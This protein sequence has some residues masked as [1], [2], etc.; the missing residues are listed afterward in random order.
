MKAQRTGGRESRERARRSIDEPPF[1]FTLLLYAA[2]FVLSDLLKPKPDLENAKPAGLGDFQFPTATEGRPV[3]LVWGTVKVSGPNVTWYGDLRQEAITIEVK[4][5][6]FSGS[7]EQVVGF[8]YRLGM[9]L[10]LC[11]GPIDELRKVWIG[12]KLVFTGSVTHGNTLTIDEP[13][14]FG[15]D[16]LGQGG[17]LATLRLFGGTNNQAASTYLSA[18]YVNAA[19]IVNAGAGYSVGQILTVQGG[20]FTIPARIKVTT[21]GGGGAITGAVIQSRGNYSAFPS[22]PAAVDAGA[23]TFNLT[24]AGF[25]AVGGVTPAYPDICYLVP[26][27]DPPYLGNSTSIQPWSFEI[28]RCPNALAVTA[29]RHVVNDGDANPMCVLFEALTNVDWGRGIPTAEIN[30]VNLRAVAVTLFDE[31]NGFS[32]LLDRMEDVG[33]LIRRI[34]E[35]VSGV[36]YQ[37]PTNGLWEFKLT[38]ADYDPLTIPELNSTNI[39]EIRTFT[40][41][42]WEGCTNQVRVPFSQRDDSY[43]DTYGFAQDMALV[44]IIGANVSSSVTHP[45]IKDKTLANNVA[46]RTLRT[47]AIPLAQGVFVVDRTFYGVLPGDVLALTDPDLGFVRL[48]MRVKSVDYGHLL[49]GEILIDTVQDVFYSAQGSFAPPAPSSWTPPSDSLV[50]FPPDEQRAFEAPRALTLRDPRSS[51]AIADMVYALAR[52]QGPEVSFKMMQRNA[53]G[54]PAG[55]FAEFGESFGF[56]RIGALNLALP[57]GSAVPLSTLLV[58]PTPDTQGALEVAFPDVT[59]LVQ[60]GTDLLTLCLIDEEFILVSSAQNNGANVQLNNVYR[61]VLDSVQAAH[62]IGA[63]VYLVFV[64]AAMGAL[65]IPA[66]RNVE[67]KLLPRSQSA[68]VPEASATTIAFTM[69]NRTRRPY[70]PC[71]LSLNSSR[72]PSSASLEGTGSGEAIGIGLTFRRRDFRT[73]DEIGA[74]LADAATLFADFP[75]ANSTTHEVDVRNDPNGANTLLF[76]QDLAALASG[77]LRRLDI[78]EATN[79]DLPT[80]LRVALRAKHSFEST[81]YASRYDLVWDFNITSALTGFFEFTALLKDEI[82][83]VFT[84]VNDTTD[85]VFTLSSAFTVGDVEYRINAGAWTQLIAAGNTSGTIPNAAILAGDTIEVVHRS[86]DTNAQKLL[87]MAAGSTPAFGVLYT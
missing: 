53:V 44:R 1:W 47:L 74:L 10:A 78:L 2:L 5:G 61:G 18:R 51:S 86:T 77:T 29:D 23:A 9:Q 49:E 81:V 72:F 35:Q 17:V 55:A 43:K 87:T 63:P 79:G 26:D 45:G 83:A 6:I 54:S 16:D 50:P 8:K 68:L 15:G 52:R 60:L 22:N 76:T 82:S 4:T 85:H 56:V 70:A 30:Q 25:Q 40:R 84:V 13:E 7:E 69:A 34:E 14:L 48:P 36:L 33:A 67:V 59:D 73:I 38:R 71:E 64:G 57:A 65:S 42:T 58:T 27:V 31:G 24:T 37:N 39:L 20:T 62:L 75:G 32:M 66:G 11:T 3:P 46:W 12:D 41:G 80:R 19:A 28:R 21:V